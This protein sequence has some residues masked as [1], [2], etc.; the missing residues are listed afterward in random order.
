MC[1]N[2][3][4]TRY[5][6]IER[7]FNLPPL[8]IDAV[9][10]EYH[11]KTGIDVESIPSVEL[12]LK[13]NAGLSKIVMSK[14]AASEEK[15]KYKNS[16][17]IEISTESKNDKVIVS[18][19][20]KIT[21]TNLSNLKT[22]LETQEISSD[23]F[24]LEKNYKEATEDSILKYLQSIGAVNKTPFSADGNYYITKG[25]LFE[26]NGTDKSKA[27]RSIEAIQRVN[28]RYSELIGKDLIEIVNTRASAYIKINADALQ[29]LRNKR[30][31]EKIPDE[32]L[33]QRLSQ[34][35]EKLG[36]N[37]NLTDGIRDN[38]GNIIPNVIGRA[39]YLKSNLSIIVDVVEGKRGLD[40][41]PEET[42][43]VA[44]WMMRGT[45]LYNVMMNDVTKT[46]TYKAV[47]E[48]YKDKYTTD[49]EF[50]EEAIAKLIAASIVRQSKQG[51]DLTE[52]EYEALS[53]E[54]GRA[55]RWFTKVIDY[56]KGLF[57]KYKTSSFDYAAMKILLE[58][59]SDLSK[60]NIGNSTEA[61]QLDENS[62]IEALANKI[63]ERKIVQS[64]GK[65]SKGEEINVYTEDGVE[66]KTTVTRDIKADKNLVRTELQKVQDEVKR[67]Y[68][69]A[70][71]EQLRNAVV[72]AA[73][74]KQTGKSA[75]TNRIIVEGMLPKDIAAIEVFAELLVN[76]YPEG[77]Q[78][79]TE[80]TVGDKK[81]YK[82]GS[83][84]LVI[85]YKEDGE[86]KLDIYDYKFT[87]FLKKDGKVIYDEFYKAKKEDYLKQIK[88]YRIILEEAYG[89][90]A[91]GK[92]RLV[93]INLNVKTFFDKD[94]KPVKWQVT[95]IEI[96]DL[97]YNEDKKYLTPIPLESER[98]GNKTI[99]NII[100]GLIKERDKIE[101]VKENTASDKVVRT[102]RLKSINE[103]IKH[104]I[105]TKNVDMFLVTAIYELQ[106]MM[107]ETNL[108][109]LA[110]MDSS[111]SF[112]KNINFS[113]YKKSISDEDYKSIKEKINQFRDLVDEA[114]VV[115]EGKV[116]KEVDRII[117][118]EEITG[119]RLP[120]ND[121][122]IWSRLF[123]S[124]STQQHPKIQ[125]LYKLVIKSK[126]QVKTDID[127]FNGK[128]EKALKGVKE[129]ASAN[130]VSTGDIFGFM[131]TRDSKG[132]LKLIPKYSKDI[133]ETLNK[134]RE[135]KDYATLKKYYT[136]DKESYD[137][138]AKAN[139]SYWNEYYK[140]EDKE[141]REKL[142]KDKEDTF[143]K[144]YNVEKHTFAY[145]SKGNYYIK[146]KEDLPKSKEFEKIEKS[147]ALKE[148][149]D[150][151]TNFVKE[152]RQ[153]LG[154]EYKG[155]F[156]PQIMQSL[157]EQMNST[158]IGAVS[159]LK[160][161]FWN[162]VSARYQGNYGEVN[163]FTGQI[164]YK[165]PMPYVESLGDKSSVDLGKVLSL[166]GMA[167]YNNKHMREV[168]DSAHLLYEALKLEK[169]YVT[170]LLG[171]V[172]LKEDGS[173][174]TK[175]ASNSNTLE[176][177]R[178]FMNESIYGVNI[179][180]DKSFTVKRKKPVYGDNG[181]VKKDENNNTVY[182]TYDFEVSGFK[183]FNKVLQYVSGK[184]LGLNFVS[185]SAN[186]FGGMTNGL[187]EGAKGTFY[188]RSEFLKGIGAFT[189]GKLNKELLT[190]VKYFDILGDMEAFNKANNLSVN[191]A[192][193]FFTYDKIYTLQKGGDSLVINSILLAMLQSHGISPD[194]KI[195]HLSE[196]E[197]G[198]K[199]IKD[200]SEIKDGNLY[201]K[202]LT[203][204]A[205][206]KEYLKFR[207]KV[208]EVSK[209][210]MGMSPTHDVRL[211]NQYIWGRA[212]MQFRN[213][214]PRMASERGGSLKYNVNL[215]TFEQ[216]R[217]IAFK[218][219]I[220]NNIAKN[221]VKTLG[222]LVGI[223]NNMEEVFENKFDLL[224][225]EKRNFLITKMGGDINNSE[226][227]EKAKQAY[228]KMMKG[229]VKATVMELQALLSVFGLLL[230]VKGGDDDD[231]EKEGLRKFALTTLTRFN[232]E[233]SFFVNPVSFNAI[234]KSPFGVT[235]TLTDITNFTGHFLGEGT[236]VL[237]G[238]QEMQDKYKPV[239]YA[240]KLF[241]I[242]SEVVRNLTVWNG[243][244]YWK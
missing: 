163:T 184:A 9:L 112:Y 83:I 208:L 98:T 116:E 42:A 33:E 91:K 149:Y 122:G 151:F 2:R 219:F 230:L 4:H 22:D 231:E 242:S 177:F 117:Q 49:I 173:P 237:I 87:E 45:H 161:R 5:K 222:M 114:K 229:N 217:Y 234:L 140:H 100:E 86:L 36:V 189:S 7:Y 53:E 142:L 65:D 80:V 60:D 194:G 90:T 159:G 211:V 182:E 133:L 164:D 118:D 167:Y 179:K 109:K 241:P 199:S 26:D 170:D 160:D 101:R 203:D 61:F 57:E 95:G 146:L 110:K 207:N 213:W 171:K 107:L 88:E 16:P 214:I 102:N 147:P 152:S 20:P 50:K 210:V 185:A 40:T 72:R 226:D 12:L 145:A 43:H 30:V 44:I 127:I 141:T 56:I 131:T 223:G 17:A 54:I 144:K 138:A 212:F 202:G 105:I 218:E 62:D 6:E 48:E 35:L 81:K 125:A 193:K 200:L 143:E 243:E 150:L 178:D 162:Q 75:T 69:T 55:K 34:F 134:A 94:K 204:S 192:E 66:F 18:Y 190:S 51:T 124:F 137:K 155:T 227:I 27:E 19:R 186:V 3:N 59:T 228:V 153:D 188:T 29:K 195:K 15:R 70:G 176:A 181:E 205:D 197:K 108:T 209:K 32:Q 41:L 172:K 74:I 233:L 154:L 128:I 113:D 8:V 73:Q 37:Y 129:Y 76:S 238:D 92:T 28:N 10:Q 25:R 183:L 97:D 225:N 58:D 31:E 93:P 79:L 115:F 21:L 201:I 244:D 206:N 111:F 68:G 175:D 180:G 236:G 82:A 166:W 96:G 78:F 77:T 13:I 220:G 224:S 216:G 126:G 14:D 169:L 67:L 196:L 232:N 135:N 64:K 99:D 71:H 121:I 123:S 191:E 215:E 24:Q 38:E 132:N 84:D 11:S 221:S 239:K 85:I 119:N 148:F 89:I 130:G 103:T 23:V 1:Y 46:S 39:K 174:V 47:L 165:I 157:I 198:S 106:Q 168:E 136:F 104:L 63:K 235:A 240:G 52:K 158:G 156:V 187:I 139:S 120:Q